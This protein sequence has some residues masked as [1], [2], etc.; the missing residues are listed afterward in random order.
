MK[1]KRRRTFH[2]GGMTKGSGMIEPMMA[3]MLAS[4]PATHKWNRAC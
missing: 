3:T 1:W 4:S 2:V